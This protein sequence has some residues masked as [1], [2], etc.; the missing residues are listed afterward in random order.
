M[1]L[2]GQQQPRAPDTHP[3]VRG[4]DQLA[5]RRVHEARHGMGRKLL[6]R[7]HIQEIGRARGVCEPRVGLGGGDE[8]HLVGRGEPARACLERSGIGTVGGF[9][10]IAPARP[11]LELEA[12][13]EPPLRAVFQRV[14]RIG[15]AQI[16]Q[17]LR[18]DDGARAAGAIDDD[19]GLRVG[20]EV[21]DAQRQ[22][23]VRAADAAGDAH[24]G[25]FAERAAIDD[26]EILG[27]LA[28]GLQ[29]SRRH[30]GRVPLVLDELAERLARDVDASVERVAGAL[31]RRR[32][33]R[34][35]VDVAVAYGLRPP[36]GALG[37]AV[38]AVAEHE[39]HGL[40]RHQRRQAR[41]E[42]AI[43]QRH[44]EKQ[45]SLAELARLAHIE[46]RHLAGV[47]EPGLQCRRIDSSGHAC[48][49]CSCRR[50]A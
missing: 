3:L 13:E 29:V 50:Q 43:G 42:A 9:V 39:P 31:P 40:V 17:R 14:D 10:G 24:L 21:A 1:L 8:F 41:L 45:M 18:A 38:T 5:A 44:G 6:R 36:G 15:D 32:P 7:A 2:V 26:D 46:Q 37:N 49:P 22:L 19:L 27:G 48:H 33:S 25:V 47:G 16:D 12:G 23:A 4:L 34:Q 35:D 20:N 28:H 11:M 30:P